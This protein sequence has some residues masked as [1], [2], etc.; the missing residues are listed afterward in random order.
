MGID[1]SADRKSTT[2]T[3]YPYSIET[4]EGTLISSS[5]QL[6]STPGEI[7]ESMA[8]SINFPPP[9]NYSIDFTGDTIHSGQIGNALYNSPPRGNFHNYNPVDNLIWNF[10]PYQ[11]PSR[12]SQDRNLIN[13]LK[14]LNTDH[15]KERKLNRINAS[16]AALVARRAFQFSAIDGTGLG[17]SS[18][19][20][21]ILLS[22]LT[23][24]HDEHH[25]KLQTKSFYPFRLVLSGDEFMKKVDF[26]G[27]VIRLNPAA[28]P[29]QWLSTLQTVTD[30]SVRRLKG[31]RKLLK[32]NLLLAENFLNVRVTK[33][34]SCDP[35]DYHRFI[36]RLA[37]TSIDYQP[38]DDGNTS[39]TPSLNNA[40]LV[41]ESE[42][43]CRR[44]K[45]RKDGNIQAG[46]GMSVEEIRK[47]LHNFASQSNEY[48]RINTQNQ[49]ECKQV[50]ERVVYEYG[51]QS[52]Q[53]VGTLVTYAQML[54]CL[55]NLLQK[56]DDE[57]EV[58][59]G[60]VGG[61]TL[62]VSHGQP[63][64]LGDDG[65]IVLPWDFC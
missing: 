16:A 47:G 11:N 6:N 49:K 41:I 61:H 30:E 1:S 12:S 44:A 37:S 65:S 54:E 23:A 4:K 29:L 24:L 9:P 59:R 52:V 15:I 48:I 55:T 58:L 51:V 21:T 32:E 64:H 39:L 10:G 18:A 45:V 60:F 46:A 8:S 43:A 40:C 33:G 62:G 26:Y 42:Q 56:G 5:I 3:T 19:S 50:Q 57:K 20:L 13:F 22:R 25:S 7:L 27:G 17:W 38:R 2:Y 35:E 31:N 63:C 28:T 14:A 36:E 34:Y 53:K